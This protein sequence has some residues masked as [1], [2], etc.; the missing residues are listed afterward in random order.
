MDPYIRIRRFYQDVSGNYHVASTD[1]GIISLVTAPSTVANDTTFIQK[2][3]IEITTVNAG[4][5]LWTF[6]DG[7]G[8]PV[9]IVPSIATSSI[10]HFD[11]DFGPG[12]VPC[13]QGTGFNI[14]ITVATG[15]VGWVAW[16]GYR[17]RTAVVSA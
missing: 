14:N 2:I 17:K 3:H 10:A 8:T 5:E 13:T 15:A 4:G 11:F 16:E 7:A 12:G 9:P 6:Q 1:T